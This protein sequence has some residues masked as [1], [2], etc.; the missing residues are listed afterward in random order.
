MSTSSLLAALSPDGSR[1]AVVLG[2]ASSNSAMVRVQIRSCDAAATLQTTLLHRES[3][4]TSPVS[5][6]F[7]ASERH[8]GVRCGDRLV[9]IWDLTRGVVCATITPPHSEQVFRHVVVDD[10]SSD[11]SSDDGKLYVLVW[12]T[13]SHKTQIHVHDV[14]TGQVLQKLKAGKVALPPQAVGVTTAASSGHPV[15]VVRHANGL[16]V[17]DGATGQK[18]SKV[19]DWTVSSALAVTGDLVA[20][21][22]QGQV[23]LSLASSGV[24]VATLPATEED[25]EQQ[26]A[27]ELWAS[28]SSG[29]AAAA[30]VYLRVGAKVYTHT[31]GG[32]GPTLLANIQ[33]CPVADAR[34]LQSQGQV[35]YALLQKGTHFQIQQASLAS[36]ETDLALVWHEPPPPAAKRKA[37]EASVLG[38]AQAGGEARPKKPRVADDVDMLL[39]EEEEKD[40]GPS[41][42]ERLLKLQQ[43]LDAEDDEDETA[44]VATSVDFTPKK[45]TTESLTKL[46][47]QALQSSDDAMLELALQVSNTKVIKETCQELAD[48]HLPTLLNALTS[49]LASKPTRANQLCPWISILLRTGR[50]RSVAHLQPLRNLLQE[51]LEIFPAL[52]KLEGRLGMLTNL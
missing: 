15:V 1:M 36:A 22:S 18:L 4:N 46:L 26:Q 8:V 35:V 19:G 24:P 48:D 41:I 23:I 29:S 38:P 50:I 3:G 12:A 20:T 5:Q 34:V 9:L 32:A 16:R 21:R 43:A 52:L 25:D 17:L 30:D 2:S 14:A 7:F 6:V 49:R 44:A 10:S 47:E 51:R 45:A 33:A 13:E 11:D 39:D 42:A 28:S 40:G 37:A 27:L 31:A